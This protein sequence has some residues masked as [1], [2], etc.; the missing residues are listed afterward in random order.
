[1]KDN[2]VEGTLSADHH[3]RFIGLR[4]GLGGEEQAVVDVTETAS[5]VVGDGLLAFR[6]Y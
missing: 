6:A 2:D 5:G 4:I 1:M 3:C